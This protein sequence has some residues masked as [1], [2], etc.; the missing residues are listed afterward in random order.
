MI[1]S[2]SLQGQLVDE[3]ASVWRGGVRRHT[4]LQPVHPKHHT[5][6]ANYKH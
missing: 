2:S 1:P 4:A 5:V 3:S 6:Y